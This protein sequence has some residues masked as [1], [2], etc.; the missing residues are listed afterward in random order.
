[1]FDNLGNELFVGN[2]VFCLSGK[3]KNTIQKITSFRTINEY[4]GVREA[5]NFENGS[6]LMDYNTISLNALGVTNFENV[7]KSGCDTLGNPIKEGDKVLFL[8]PMEM[9]VEI[10]VV[11]KLSPQ[12]CL[13]SI[14]KNRFGQTEYRKKYNELISLTALSKEDIGIKK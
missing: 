10:G 3:L 13:L 6:W 7:C 2:H 9:Y 4:N 8:H 1:M 11:K 12:S 14:N 5:V